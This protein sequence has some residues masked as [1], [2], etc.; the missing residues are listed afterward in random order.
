MSREI[1]KLQQQ[2]NRFVNRC[3]KLN[4]NT[5]NQI[6]NYNTKVLQTSEYIFIIYSILNL[7]SN[8]K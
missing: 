2:P 1:Y 6:T 8:I 3:H 7:H 5:I 4:Q